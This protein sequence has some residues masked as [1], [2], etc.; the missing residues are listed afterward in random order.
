M[1]QIN[2]E[3][4]TYLSQGTQKLFHG[5]YYGALEDFDSAIRADSNNAEAYLMRGTI[6]NQLR[7]HVEAIE[8]FNEAI[9]I[10]P[11]YTDAYLHRGNAN[12]ILGIFGAAIDD[13][14]KVISL[15]SGLSDNTTADAY[16]CRGV[17]KWAQGKRGSKEYKYNKYEDAINDFNEAIRLMPNHPDAHETRE[18]V[19]QALYKKNKGCL[20]SLFAIINL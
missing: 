7:E 19:T 14:D 11:D 8:D 1:K 15:C 20:L 17:A 3:S 13:F 5:A 16:Y 18:I 2:E 6:K 12:S 4:K 10:K 9:K